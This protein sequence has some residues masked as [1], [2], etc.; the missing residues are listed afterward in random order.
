M[1]TIDKN[2]SIRKWRGSSSKLIEQRTAEEIYSSLKQGG[3][4]T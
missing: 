3:D 2:L 4:A 1:K